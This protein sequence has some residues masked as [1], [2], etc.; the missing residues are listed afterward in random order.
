MESPWILDL[1]PVVASSKVAP[2]DLP[3]IGRQQFHPQR[4]DESIYKERVGGGANGVDAP[5]SSGCANVRQGN[6]AILV[7]AVT[8]RSGPNQ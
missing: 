4:P 7:L 2:L 3:L 1:E 6:E 5:A 8:N